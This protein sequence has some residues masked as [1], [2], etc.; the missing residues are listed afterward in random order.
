MIRICH[1]TL[2]HLGKRAFLLKSERY[3][4]RRASQVALV[5][6]NLLD[7]A[8]DI[9][10]WVCSLGWEDPLEEGTA[11]H[12]SILAGR[13]PWTEEP[14]GLVHEVTKTWTRLKPLNNNTRLGDIAHA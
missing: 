4:V 5:V 6:K 1:T 8:R 11:T 10:M 2:C 3:K 12:S 7:S 13:V 9:K 14:G